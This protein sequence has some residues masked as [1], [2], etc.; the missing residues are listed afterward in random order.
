[1]WVDRQTDVTRLIVPLRNFV[2]DT[3]NGNI[4]G[5]S[6][7]N[8]FSYERRW[9]LGKRPDKGCCSSC[10]QC[11][12]KCIQEL[13]SFTKCTWQWSYQHSKGM[14]SQRSHEHKLLLGNRKS[15]QNCTYRISVTIN[16]YAMGFKWLQST[17]AYDIIFARHLNFSTWFTKNIII[18]GTKKDLIMD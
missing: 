11:K 5:V 2:N 18:S 15:F 8:E 14:S 16:L 4:F 9:H 10:R 7:R 12:K 3:I 6:S 1:M 17:F 13:H